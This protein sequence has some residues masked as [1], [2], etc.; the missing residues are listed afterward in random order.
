VPRD[1]RR[2]VRV[3]DVSIM[4]DYHLRAPVVPEPE[5]WRVWLDRKRDVAELL[6]AV[7][8]DRFEVIPTT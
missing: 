6:T 8:A 5:E 2:L 3:N 4:T 7:R 1:G